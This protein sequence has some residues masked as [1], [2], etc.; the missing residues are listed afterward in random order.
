MCLCEDRDLSL[1]WLRTLKKVLGFNCAGIV[2]WSLA[3]GYGHIVV[4]CWALPVF[5]RCLFYRSPRRRFYVY[6]VIWRGW[7]K[8]EYSEVENP[9]KLKLDYKALC[10]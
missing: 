1:E 5:S 3:R 2:K 7:P 8:G 4:V 9:I 10:Q 6:W